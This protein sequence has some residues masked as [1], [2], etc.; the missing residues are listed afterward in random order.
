MQWKPE[1]AGRVKVARLH[2]YWPDRDMSPEEADFMATHLTVGSLWTLRAI[3]AVDNR[4][5]TPDYVKHEYSYLVYGS[6]G[7]PASFPAG[8]PA[9]YVG[10][11]RVEED[12][13]GNPIRSLRHTFIVGGC[14]YMVINVMDVMQPA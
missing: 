2:P 5:A 14:R 11:V 7:A 6:W 12:N 3:M 1:E 9:V 8:T 13:R 4:Y 10:P